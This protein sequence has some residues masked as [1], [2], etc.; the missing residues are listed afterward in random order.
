[1]DGPKGSGHFEEHTFPPVGLVCLNPED[2]SV[3]WRAP[4]EGIK[5]TEGFSGPQNGYLSIAG[6]FGF[7][8]Q[9]LAWN[10]GLALFDANTGEKLWQRQ[11]GGGSRGYTFMWND[12]VMITGSLSSYTFLDP[13]MVQRLTKLA[14]VVIVVA[15]DL[16]PLPKI[17]LS[18]AKCS[19]RLITSKKLTQL[20]DLAWLSAT[21]VHGLWSDVLADVALWLWILFAVQCCGCR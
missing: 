8:K 5:M 10:D 13:A 11:G 4:V 21:D 1:M 6:N 12:Q 2:G 20:L 9:R 17:I 18:V 15:A 16:R 7:G 19:A 14:T 3:A